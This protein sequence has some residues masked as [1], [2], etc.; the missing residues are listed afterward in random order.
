MLRPL[1]ESSVLEARS[2][3]LRRLEREPV[4]VLT[5]DQDWA[6]SWTSKA[7][8]DITSA[9]QVPLHVFRTNACA[10]LDAAREAGTSTNGWHPNFGAGSS[11]GATPREVVQHMQTA[12]PS[13]RTSRSHRFIESTEGWK[14]LR[15]AGIV[16]DSQFATL[17]ASA[18]RPLRHWTGIVR[19]PVF[20]EDDI[21][22]E[23]WPVELP[24]A[25]ISNTLFS[26][27]LKVLNFHPSFVGCNTPSRAFYESTRG[28]LFDSG[29]SADRL[30]WHKRGTR[31]VLLE[32]LELIRSRGAAFERFEDIAGLADRELE[33]PL[34]NLHSS[35]MGDVR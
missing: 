27:G 19:I 13:C 35:D 8:L 29:E 6:P 34:A 28:E 9:F 14:E 17:M 33:N 11:H 5:A 31:D 22:F 20:L 30:I 23:Y 10:V 4:F 15:R 12:F 21:F 25:A 1:R 26:P 16:A 24:L 7:L 2:E 32:L 3:L 18:I